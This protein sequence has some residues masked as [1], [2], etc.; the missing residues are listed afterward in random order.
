MKLGE[1]TFKR[2][3]S[4]A[5]IIVDIASVVAFLYIVFMVYACAMDIETAKSLNSTD[6]SLDFLKWQPLIIWCVAGA[7]VWAV[8]VAL[9]LRHR[10]LPKK[11]VVTEKY[12]QKY[13]NIIDSCISCMRLVVLLTVSEFCY[14]HM[15]SLMLR[16]VI[17][18][19]QIVLQVI[20]AALLLWFTAIRLES[21]SQAAASEAEENKKRVIIEN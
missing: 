1:F 17:F 8:S 4:V 21:V 16:T 5:Q 10:K 14:M 18:P 13:C 20:I 7:A 11:Y 12:A 3:Y 2:R 19:I 9:L 6:A 15:C